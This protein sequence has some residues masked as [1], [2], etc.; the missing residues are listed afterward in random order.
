[1]RLESWVISFGIQVES[2][3]TMLFASGSV[4]PAL[5]TNAAAMTIRFEL[6][7]VV[8]DNE[9]L[10]D[11]PPMNRYCGDRFIG[12]ASGLALTFLGPKF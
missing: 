8:S 9:L 11:C 10:V 4:I 6:S 3:S 7:E 5:T 2:G 12:S 1:M